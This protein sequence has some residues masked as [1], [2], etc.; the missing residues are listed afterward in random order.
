MNEVEAIEKVISGLKIISEEELDKFQVDG[1]RPKVVVEPESEDEIASLLKIAND[2]GFTVI[3]WGGGTM[4]SLGNIPKCL[5]IVI[6]L[7]RLNKI[8]EYL[9]ED[10]VVTSEAGVTLEALQASLLKNKQF[11]PLDP[12]RSEQATLGGIVSS[13]SFGPLRYLYG[14]VRDLLL[15][16]KVVGANGIVMKFGGKV[17]KNVAGY[18]IKKLFIGSLGTLGI[19]TQTT[20]RLYA[21]PE[22]EESFI[23]TF[24]NIE[25]LSGASLKILKTIH[26][27]IGIGLS[28]V[29]ILD[30]NFCELLK[31]LGTTEDYLL[32]TRVLGLTKTGLERRIN[33]LK[34]I[35]KD[36]S[37]ANM[38]TLNDDEHIKFWNEIKNHPD[39]ASTFFVRCKISTLISRVT[40][41]MKKIEE[42]K[43]KHEIKYSIIA[44][45]GLGI[46]HSYF[47]SLNYDDLI[48]TLDELRS[49]VINIGSG[50]SLVIETAPVEIKRLIN[51]WGPT[52]GDFA[53]MRAIKKAFDPKGILSP[54]RFVGGI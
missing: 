40:S 45:I 15:G 8:V 26:S 13:N 6:S 10:L 51:V 39:I 44:H 2:K 4:M 22:Y 11:L 42:L 27:S 33:E 24:K 41:V 38:I 31:H 43:K 36:Y 49:Y 28:A 19:I 20:F 46:I 37:P 12:P 7:K 50:S 48:K 17:V 54:G 29:E 53:L 34:E 21:I 3:P 16:I 18:D 30:P 9:P 32:A 25:D 47:Y 14:C 1:V 5:D 35:V 52:R 23:C